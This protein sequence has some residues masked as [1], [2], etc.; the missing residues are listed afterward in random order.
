[1]PKIIA[2]SATDPT[3]LVNRYIGK[4]HCSCGCV[5]LVAN[6]EITPVF[7][8]LGYFRIESDSPRA[9]DFR[10][11]RAVIFR[12]RLL[13]RIPNTKCVNVEHHQSDMLPD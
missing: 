5:R 11:Q 8:F 7:P 4:L 2:K 12:Q 13:G 3:P 10:D 9:A 6:W 1:L